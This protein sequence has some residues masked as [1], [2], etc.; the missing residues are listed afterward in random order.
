MCYCGYDEEYSDC[1]GQYHQGEPAP[2]AE[3]LM[4]SR[5]TAYALGLF[6]YIQDTMEGAPAADFDRVSA[7]Q[8]HEV[9]QWTRLDVL[10][11]KAGSESETEGTVDFVAHFVLDDQKGSFREESRF[12]KRAGRWYYVSGKHKPV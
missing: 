12:V 7:E 9:M 6:D 4:R 2:T 11:S 3:T 8:Q 1:C 5:F 10:S